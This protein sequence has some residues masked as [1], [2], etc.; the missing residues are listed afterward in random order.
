VEGGGVNRV[1]TSTSTWL[2]YG[3]MAAN[4]CPPGISGAGVGA[5]PTTTGSPAGGTTADDRLDTTAFTTSDTQSAMYPN[6]T[7]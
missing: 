6:P 3:F 7:R 5:G 1:L 2:Q 4:H